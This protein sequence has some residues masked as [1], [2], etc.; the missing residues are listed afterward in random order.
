MADAKDVVMELTKGLDV[1]TIE[2]LADQIEVATISIINLSKVILLSSDEE[3][4]AIKETLCKREEAAVK[5][6]LEGEV[7]G[8]EFRIINILNHLISQRESYKKIRAIG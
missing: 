6:T 3:I 7:T 1:V 8:L 5:K 4:E 2:M